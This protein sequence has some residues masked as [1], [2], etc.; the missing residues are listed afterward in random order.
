MSE[1]NDNQLPDSIY[2]GIG[3]FKIFIYFTFFLLLGILLNFNFSKVIDSTIKSALKKMRSCPIKYETVAM[4]MFPPGISFENLQLSGSC[5]G[6]KN[7]KVSLSESA[8]SLIGP[9]FSP[10]GLKFRLKGKENKTKLAIYA[11]VSPLGQL[12]KMEKIFLDKEF[13]KNMTG[14]DVKIDLSLLVDAQIKIS[15]NDIESASFNIRSKDLFFPAQNINQI[16]PLPAIPFKT[17]KIKG[18]IKK[19][20]VSFQQL[21]IG[22]KSSPMFVDFKGSMNLN[23]KRFMESK[24]DL[25]GKLKTTEDIFTALTLFSP[26]IKSKK[27]SDGSV[28][29]SLKGSLKSPKLL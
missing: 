8:L 19:K 16:F 21:I 20:K 29:V 27:Q 18:I 22:A 4:E 25:S 5:F 2:P 28:D 14:D 11:S 26:G 15:G 6:N 10:P 24:I 1:E 3:K 7:A 12:I 13:V 17:L 23:N 9:S